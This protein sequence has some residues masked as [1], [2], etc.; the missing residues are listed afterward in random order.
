MCLITYCGATLVN[1]FNLLWV[2]LLLLTINYT[3]AQETDDITSIMQIMTLEQ[4]V[5]QMFIFSIYGESLNALGDEIIRTWQPGGITLFGSNAQN[6]GQITALTNSYQQAITE[7]GGWPMLIAT[8]QE[9]GFIQRL[10]EGFTEWPPMALLTATGDADLAHAVGAQMGRELRAVGVNMNLAPVADLDTNINNP[11]IGRRSPGSNLDLL[12]VTLPA[13]VAGLQSAG[14]SGTGKHFPGH[15]DTTEDSHVT[16]PLIRDGLDVLRERELQPFISLIAGDVD[17]IMMAHIWFNA[18]DAE[19]LPASL[20]YNIVTGLL[21]D[22][23]GFDGL[24]IT[25]AMEMQG[26]S[27]LFSPAEAAIRAVQAG[28]DMLTFGTGMGQNTQIQMVEAVIA[29][30]RDG[31]ISQS[32]IDESVRRILTVK[33]Q[34]SVLDW[35]PLD[36][37][38][39]EARINM[40]AG[41]EL[42][43]EMFRA[44]VTVA[45]DNSALIPVEAGRALLIYPANRPRIEWTCR[46]RAT[47][48]SV[49]WSVLGVGDHPT[50][51][52]IEDAIRAAG[53][54]D[55]IIV[56]TDN[57]RDSASYTRLVNAL[58][59][60]RTI[61]VAVRSPYDGLGFA[62]VGAYVLTYSPQNAG[63]ETACDVLFGRQAAYGT[64]STN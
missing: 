52:Q 61:A 57:A 41:A 11:I 59:L 22:E 14:V 25:D 64:Q 60:E 7:S 47:N 23:L 17:A 13:Y 54:A 45:F 3:E 27:A 63:I 40:S 48:A 32:R 18:I 43:E 16:L 34:R 21:R 24:I 58:P 8:D 5:A 50:Q 53:Q 6:P 31:T 56:F 12:A 19:P 62:G 39:A 38:T 9:G 35:T 10:R 26:I 51:A 36:V 30:V 20:S 33:A 37:T 1:K 55:T 46:E 15:G 44:G 29:A 28:N 4:K 2:A 49:G 42:V